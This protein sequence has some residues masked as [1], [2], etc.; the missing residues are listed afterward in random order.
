MLGPSDPGE[1]L[2]AAVSAQP[3]L[4]AGLEL[5]LLSAQHEGKT[6]PH[7]PSLWSD[8]VSPAQPL[9]Y[10]TTVP[11][12]WPLCFY[13]SITCLVDFGAFLQQDL[14]PGLQSAFSSKAVASDP[15]KGSEAHFPL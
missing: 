4:A 11:K 2:K 9:S 13:L 1:A 15:P 14:C 6:W 3:S 10:K 8:H 5:S 7:A 12:S